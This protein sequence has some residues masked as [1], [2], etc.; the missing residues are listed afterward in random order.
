MIPPDMLIADPGNIEIIHT[1]TPQFVVLRVGRYFLPA[2]LEILSGC[3][4]LPSPL[5]VFTSQQ[6]VTRYYEELMQLQ[7]SRL[8]PPGKR[9]VH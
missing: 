5:Q 1:T 2:T 7:R 8:L 3:L 9:E 6:Q 4:L